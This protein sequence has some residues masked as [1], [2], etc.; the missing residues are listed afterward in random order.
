MTVEL[1][2]SILAA[3]WTRMGEQIAEAEAAGA[4]WLHVDVMDGSFVPNISFGQDMVAAAR[5]ASRLP[6][7]VHLM[8]V[9]PLRH[10]DSFARAGATRISVHAEAVASL[11]DALQALRAT[12]C[13]CG[14]ALNPQ[15][16]ADV[17]DAVLPELD[18][19]LVMT[20]N[21]GFGGQAF[22]P[23]T[24]PGIRE[25]RARIAEWGR[26]ITLG[27]DGGMNTETAPQAVAAGASFV[28]AGSSVFRPD[29][30]VAAGMD[31]LRAAI[32]EETG[33]AA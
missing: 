25:L 1:A 32:L 29:Q 2:P 20:V 13:Q 14:V 28:I 16:P 12:G 26:D 33:G 6:L 3:D 11:P 23:E 19:I 22:M 5:R 31:A 17:V 27:V 30:T 18:Y 4:D 9:E 21:P 7:D 10:I 15:T 8:I 24:L